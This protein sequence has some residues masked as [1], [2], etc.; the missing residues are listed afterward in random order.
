MAFPETF[1]AV[2][3]QRRMVIVVP[4]T[5][6]LVRCS[7]TLHRAELACHIHEGDGPQSISVKIYMFLSL[8]IVQLLNKTPFDGPENLTHISPPTCGRILDCSVSYSCS[9]RR[10]RG[11]P[12]TVRNLCE[13]PCRVRTFQPQTAAQGRCPGSSCTSFSASSGSAWSSLIRASNFIGS[14]RRIVAKLLSIFGM[15]LN[16]NRSLA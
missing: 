10:I 3:T 16:E 6:R 1:T 11:K 14:Q 12:Y 2:Y 15:L 5:E 13:A 7:R 4:R 9:D 8:H